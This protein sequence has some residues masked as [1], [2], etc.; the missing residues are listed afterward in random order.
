MEALPVEGAELAPGFVGDL[1]DPWVR[2][3]ADAL[4]ENT[5]RFA[6]SGDL[7]ATFPE[8]AAAVGT[9]VLHRAHLSLGDCERVRRLRTRRGTSV[10]IVL[11]VGPH[12]RYRELE[13]WNPLVD[14]ILH[15]A[16]ARETVTRHVSPLSNTAHAAGPRPPVTVVSSLY[17]MRATLADACEAAGYPVTAVAGWQEPA[18]GG[19]AVWDVPVLDDDWPVALAQQ[20]RHRRVVALLGIADRVTVSLARAQGAAACLDLPC[21]PHD[22]AFVLDRVSRS[23]EPGHEV[24][25]PPAFRHPRPAVPQRKKPSGA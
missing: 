6:C 13:R 15:E 1:D 10:R 24:P 11:C 4:P 7:P 17:E 22:L 25:P 12:A 14:A 16:T 20:A 5:A 23:L 19:L 9:L 2:A 18:G 21:D 8:D 3:I